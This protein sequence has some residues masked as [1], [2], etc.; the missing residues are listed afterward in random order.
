VFS[1]PSNYSTWVEHWIDR[2]RIK[3]LIS[4]R[5]IYK[6][7]VKKPFDVR[8]LTPKGFFMRN[9]NIKKQRKSLKSNPYGK[10]RRDT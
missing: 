5:K 6:R 9:S 1:Q 7:D 2:I 8:L 4:R 10:N 3:R